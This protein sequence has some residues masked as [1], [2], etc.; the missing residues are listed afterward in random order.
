[1]PAMPK[2][3]SIRSVFKARLA[4][5]E[6]ALAGLAANAPFPLATAGGEGWGVAQTL[7]ARGVL[8]HAAHVVDGK[9]A[10]YQVQ[11]PTDGYFSDASALSSL[12]DN[13][14]F[15]SQDQARQVLNQA[16]LALDPC[17]PYD[18]ELNDA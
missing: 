17:L 6:A 3:H 12:L 1:M 8:T 7:T 14:E 18:V 16:I 4:E 5:V 10:S 13:L 9:V 15:A 2:P 11:A